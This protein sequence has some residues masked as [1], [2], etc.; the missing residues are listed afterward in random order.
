[1]QSFKNFLETDSD[2]LQGD[3]HNIFCGV[4]ISLF[5]KELQEKMNAHTIKTYD[6]FGFVINCKFN[7]FNIANGILIISIEGPHIDIYS[8]RKISVKFDYQYKLMTDP[9]IIVSPLFKYE[10]L[11]NKKRNNNYIISFIIKDLEKKLTKIASET[12]KTH[13]DRIKKGD[14]LPYRLTRML[15]NSLDFEN[16]PLDVQEAMIE[17]DYKNIK[18]IN[19]PDKI[20]QDKVMSLNLRNFLL[21]KNPYPEL[22]KKYKYLKDMSKGGIL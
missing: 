4:D 20:I 7:K 5:I 3:D 19:N 17:L 11:T 2:F 22:E 13:G 8:P 16:I 14:I 1:M 18:Y 10:G 6:N 15:E 9:L 12:L 21:I